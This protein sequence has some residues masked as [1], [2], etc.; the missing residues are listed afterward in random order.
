[1]S[2]DSKVGIV[3]LGVLG[4]LVAIVAGPRVLGEVFYEFLGKAAIVLFIIMVITL[5]RWRMKRNTIRD[6]PTG[7]DFRGDREEDET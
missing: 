2:K 4:A 6:N 5:F 7:F 3:A 1:M